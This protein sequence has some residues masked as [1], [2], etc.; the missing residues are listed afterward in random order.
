M[1]L[2]LTTAL[3]NITQEVEVLNVVHELT[4][5]SVVPN[6]LLESFLFGELA[7]RHG[8]PTNRLIQPAFL[9]A[10]TGEERNLC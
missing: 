6:L 10:C 8:N 7:Y 3:H 4:I 2:S 1:P 9:G 5:K